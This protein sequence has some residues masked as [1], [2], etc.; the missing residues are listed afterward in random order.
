MMI[1]CFYYALHYTLLPYVLKVLIDR[2][3]HFLGHPEFIRACI[4][5]AI[6]LIVL[7]FAR[8]SFSRIGDYT[9]LKVFP[10][11]KADI[12]R[13]AA[14]YVSG[15]SFKFFQDNLSGSI[16]N[17][18]ADLANNAESLIRCNNIFFLQSLGIISSILISF[19]VSPLFHRFIF[20]LDSSLCLNYAVSL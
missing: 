13:Q 2:A 9:C 7:S 4:I 18:I 3:T 16:S 11:L 10:A 6:L 14:D 19:L 15:N 8:N 12:M 1:S 5:P 17:R 20:Y